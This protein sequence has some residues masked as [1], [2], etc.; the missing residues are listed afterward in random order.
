VDTSIFCQCNRT[1]KQKV[2]VRSEMADKGKNI[3]IGDPCMSN[4]L[5]GGIA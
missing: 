2:L 1:S 4:I 3:V 5:Q